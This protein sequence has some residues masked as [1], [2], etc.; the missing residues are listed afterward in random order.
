[1]LKKYL[2]L[3]E[4][5][6]AEN[7]KMWHEEKGT[8]ELSQPSGADMR[9][10]GITPGGIT[11]DLDTIGD[12]ETDDTGMPPGAEEVPGMGAP[13]G[14]GGTPAPVSAPAGGAEGSLAQ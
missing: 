14:P 13:G 2:G 6:M 9:S 3:T 11:G 12:L 7:E 10:V 5:E 1:M 8:G 4:M